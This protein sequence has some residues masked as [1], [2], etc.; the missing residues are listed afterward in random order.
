MVR[1]LTDFDEEELVAQDQHLLGP[2][3]P[4]VGK[5]KFNILDTPG[6]A[7]FIADARAR[8]RL[9]ERSCSCTPLR[10]SRFRPR[11]HGST[12]TRTRRPWCS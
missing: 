3:S 9:D 12:R 4:G 10:A 2:V 5:K 6:Y 11:R 7:N 8:A 1:S